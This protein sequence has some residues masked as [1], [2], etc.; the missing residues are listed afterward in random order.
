MEILSIAPAAESGCRRKVFPA[1][2]TG[3]HWGVWVVACW[4]LCG[5]ALHSYPPTHAPDSMLLDRNNA[6]VAHLYDVYGRYLA[7]GEFI[8]GCSGKAIAALSLEEVAACRFK[9]Q[10]SIYPA[11]LDAIRD[12][13]IK[14]RGDRLQAAALTSPQDGGLAQPARPTLQPIE[15][16]PELDTLPGAFAEIHSQKRIALVVGNSHYRYLP[17]LDNPTNDAS[18]IAETLKQ[19][20]FSL[21]RG[22]PLLDLDQAGLKDAVQRFSRELHQGSVTPS[23]TGVIALFYYAG[24]GVQDR[25]ENYLIPVDANPTKAADFDFQL[26]SVNVVLRQMGSAGT[27]LNMVVLDACRNNPFG[28][29]GLRSGGNGLAEM[30]APEGTL[31]AFATQSGN[32][33][34]DGP[35]NGN[36][37]FAKAL[38]WGFQQPN[39]DQ[40]GTFNAVALQVKRMT[41]GVQQPWMSN[42]PIE[43]RFFF[44]PP[45]A[46]ARP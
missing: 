22:G 27:N 16:Q 10:V 26:L 13:L 28:G 35:R 11:G 20:G 39:L 4:A 43:G 21:T 38:A 46:R 42:S 9:T 8:D 45:G 32:V 34:Q 7:T 15:P 17:T 5:C 40:F 1:V 44:V 6:S 18:L 19:L 2:D 29:R 37:P 3:L 12:K 24:H 30:K 23:E 25:G 33:A 31:V 36:S 14:A 41:D